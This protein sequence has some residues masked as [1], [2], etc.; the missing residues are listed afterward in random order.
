MPIDKPNNIAHNIWQ[1]YVV[2]LQD[3]IY[4]DKTYHM[5]KTYQENGKMPF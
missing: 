4:M 3:M 5:D 2:R 1:F